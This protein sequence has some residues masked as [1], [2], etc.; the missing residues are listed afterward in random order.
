MSVHT[1]FVLIK[2]DIGLESDVLKEIKQLDGVEEAYALYGT[3]DI[4][5]KVGSQS[6]EELKNIVTWQLRKLHGVRATLTL[7]SQETENRSEPQKI[8]DLPLIV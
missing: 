6:M 4:I 2:S 5:A 8:H 3:Y 1:A 7:M